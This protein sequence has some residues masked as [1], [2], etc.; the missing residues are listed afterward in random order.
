MNTIAISDL[1][2]PAFEKMHLEI[3]L[4]ILVWSFL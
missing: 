2:F 1:L 4:K 3:Y